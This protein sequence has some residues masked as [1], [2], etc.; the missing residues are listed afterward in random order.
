MTRSKS[1]TWSRA[2]WT[3]QEFISRA[4]TVDMNPVGQRNSV[5]SRKREKSKA[6]MRSIFEGGNNCEIALRN[7]IKN[8]P[9]VT[10]EYR[11][12]DGGHRKRAIWDFINNKFRLPYDL[13][14]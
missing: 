8:N 13:V 1:P 3:I 2:E 6:I 5:E 12:I 10:H 4:G 11:S 9:G 14:S 7:M